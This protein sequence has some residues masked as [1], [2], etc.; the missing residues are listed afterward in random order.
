MLVIGT[1]DGFLLGLDAATGAERW[2]FQVST[3][4]AAHNPALADGIAYVGGDDPGFFAVDAATGTLLWRGDTGDDQTATAVVAEG[5]AYIGG[6][7]D[8]GGGPP[9]R[10]RRHDGRAP[11]DARR[12][13][14]HPDRAR[15]GR[16]LRW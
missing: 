13:A 5:I 4:G 1:G 9:L 11:L 7:P 12:A 16:L 10:L 6:S 14:L 2:R 8:G 3:T 15:R